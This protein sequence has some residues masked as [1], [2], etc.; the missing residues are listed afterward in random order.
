MKNTQTGFIAIVIII[1]IALVAVGGGTY[2]YTQQKM[3]VDTESELEI[4]STSTT[5]S[6][7]TNSMQDN[8]NEAKDNLN[9][10]V[11]KNLVTEATVRTDSKGNPIP[12]LIVDPK[13]AADIVVEKYGSDPAY[14]RQLIKVQL[15]AMSAGLQAEASMINSKNGSYATVCERA[16]AFLYEKARENMNTG[17]EMHD[18]LTVALNITVDSYR[19]EELVCKSNDSGF[20]ATLPL[21]L[22][23]GTKTKM[24]MS[25]KGFRYNEAD[26]ENMTCV[27]N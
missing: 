2:V 16:K 10:S 5:S 21:T 11:G 3:N 23:D 13:I 1:V 12:A 6:T 9:T 27:I 17:D 25:S 4:N 22:E 18:Q 26:F 20:V 8:L 24:C 7:T 19:I 14:V 15:M